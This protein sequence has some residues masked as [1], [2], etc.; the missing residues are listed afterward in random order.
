MDVAW[1]ELSHPLYEDPVGG[2]SGSLWTSRTDRPKKLNVGAMMSRYG[3]TTSK[4]AMGAF[5]QASQNVK[6]SVTKISWTNLGRI[7]GALAI[8]LLYKRDF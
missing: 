4:R 6:E 2:S 7:I 3:A 1:V 8:M 5:R